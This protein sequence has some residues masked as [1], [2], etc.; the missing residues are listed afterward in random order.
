MRLARLIDP[1]VTELGGGG[2]GGGWAGADLG[3][4]SKY[5]KYHV[6]ALTS[7]TK[8]A[9]SPDANSMNLWCSNGEI[10]CQK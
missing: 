9:F 10:K 6:T 2:G 3:G 4:S 8:G 7:F 5:S 1:R